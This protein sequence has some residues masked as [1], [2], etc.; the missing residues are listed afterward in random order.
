LLV[1]G[2]ILI[3]NKLLDSSQ[4]RSRLVLVFVAGGILLQLLLKL[5]N[6]RLVGFMDL[7]SVS[8]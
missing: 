8:E 3:G 5:G 4:L 6:P 1:D 7:T 2:H